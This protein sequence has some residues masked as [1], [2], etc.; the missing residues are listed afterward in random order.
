MARGWAL[1]GVG[2]V[3]VHAFANGLDGGT[4]AWDTA[5]TRMAQFA[6][7]VVG[8]FFAH[9]AFPTL[10][11][12]FGLG[13]AALAMRGGSKRRF[14]IL[15]GVGISLGLTAWPGEILSA[16]ALIALIAGHR[17]AAGSGT[18]VRRVIYVLLL[19]NLVSVGGL[20]YFFLSDTASAGCA[21]NIPSV[22]SFALNS[23][24]AGLGLRASEWAIN[25]VASH[26]LLAPVWLCIFLGIFAAKSDDF[27]AF[28][29]NCES[30]PASAYASRLLIFCL[31][32]YLIATSLEVV[33]GTH[34][35]WNSTPCNN[36]WLALYTVSADLAALSSIP[37]IIFASVRVS[38]RVVPS[39]L[40]LLIIHVGKAPLSMFVGQSII[41][42]LIFHRAVF[43]F[44]GALTRPMTLMVAIVTYLAVAF[45]LRWWQQGGR[46]TGSIDA[47]ARAVEKRLNRVD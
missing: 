27:W 16:Y 10:A 35:A 24:R 22:S 28:V 30:Q 41:F 42:F 39:W 43:G 11:F 13:V 31:A 5:T 26:L 32:V 20:V 47:F 12:L 15:L 9:R 17:F 33:A 19:L 8:A 38:R 34:G 37:L 25:G 6:E 2:I 44:H 7:I 3:N 14:W 4:H 46:A 23:W 36:G 40:T 21:Q 18:S 29:G 1:F 45:F